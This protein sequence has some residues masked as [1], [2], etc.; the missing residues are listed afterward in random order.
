VS[1]KTVDPLSKI[2]IRE[3]V[4]YKNHEPYSINL[5][6]S[7]MIHLTAIRKKAVTTSKEHLGVKLERM[8]K[9][10]TIHRLDIKPAKIMTRHFSELLFNNLLSKRIQ[11]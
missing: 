11:I 8:K 5:N 7:L 6:V 9:A 1:G 2:S 3:D 4:V 10:T